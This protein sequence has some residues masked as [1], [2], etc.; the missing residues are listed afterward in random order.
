MKAL[1]ITLAFIA[2][3]LYV[4]GGIMAISALVNWYYK[5]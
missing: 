4:Y 1:K 5:N 2:F 3:C